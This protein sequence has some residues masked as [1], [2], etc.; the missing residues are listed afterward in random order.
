[1]VCISGIDPLNLCGTLLPGDKVAALAGNRVLFRDGVP[2][3]L[4]VAG[5]IKYPG[6]PPPV[7]RELLRAHLL[8]R[9]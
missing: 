8:S 7:E 4:Q 3:A 5:K 2:V 6:S 9:Q 1:M